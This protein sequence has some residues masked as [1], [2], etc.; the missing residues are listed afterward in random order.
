MKAKLIKRNA[1]KQTTK[2]TESKDVDQPKTQTKTWNPQQAVEA[3]IRARATL[4]SEARKGFF[5]TF[6]V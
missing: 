3:K 6:A 1:Q 4:Q 5:K 2:S